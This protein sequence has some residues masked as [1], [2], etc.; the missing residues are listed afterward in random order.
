MQLYKDVLLSEDRHREWVQA[1]EHDRLVRRTGKPT[2]SLRTVGQALARSIGM[3][4]SF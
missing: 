3:Y 1:A 2:W 4:F